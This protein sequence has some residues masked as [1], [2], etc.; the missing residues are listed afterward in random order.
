MTQY[1][2][3][4]AFLLTQLDV[5]MS[6]TDAGFPSRAGIKGSGVQPVGTGIVSPTMTGLSR[7]QTSVYENDT[8]E[9]A[10]FR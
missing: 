8:N 4:T 10:W 6:D 7:L 3:C 1:E 5:L 2:H 9:L